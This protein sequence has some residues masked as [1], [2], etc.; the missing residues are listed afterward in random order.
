MG[1]FTKL[2]ISTTAAENSDSTTK[3]T[4]NNDNNENYDDN[5]NNNKYY[6]YNHDNHNLN[7][8]NH[9]ISNFRNTLLN[10]FLGL[11]QKVSYLHL[12]FSSTKN[13]SLKWKRKKKFSSECVRAWQREREREIVCVCVCVCEWVGVI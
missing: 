13:V 4:D 12:L 8:N 3:A 6:T 10:N 7:N 2:T 9:T 11:R 5:D 1:R